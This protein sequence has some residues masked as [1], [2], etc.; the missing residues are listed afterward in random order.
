MNGL[1]EKLAALPT[2]WRARVLES[3]RVLQVPMRVR[4]RGLDVREVLLFEGTHGWAEWSPFVEYDDAES[5]IWLRAAVEF[6]FNDLPAVAHK[7]IKVN[8]TL[9][10]VAPSEVAAAL[11]PFS[12][13]EVV[14]I[15]VA[16]KGQTLADDIA[17]VREVHRLWPN[18]RIRIDANGGYSVAQT[19][20]VAQSLIDLGLP[21]EYLEQP[22]ATV[23]ELAEVRTALQQISPDAPIKVAADESVRKASDPI[24]VARAGAADVLVLKAA[25]LGGITAAMKIAAEAALPVVVSSALETSVGIS[26]G[27]HLAA[28]LDSPYASGLA[29][30]AL[31]ADDVT[32]SPLIP[33]DGQIA[34]ARVDVA[35]DALTRLAATEQRRAWWLARL[36]RCLALI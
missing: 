2:D 32:D 18:A 33:V 22:V 1:P 23:A 13:F 17:R 36:E 19:L 3:A 14:K 16:E 11:A 21:I 15:K 5:S 35:N 28:L 6:A 30:A 26:M 31:L 7:S 34:V 27:A 8:A 20:D 10:A 24:A 29:T 12:A 25:P 4:F 9:P